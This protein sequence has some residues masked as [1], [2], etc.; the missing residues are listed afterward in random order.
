MTIAKCRS[1]G[2][3]EKYSKELPVAAFCRGLLPIGP[4]FAGPIESFAAYEIQVCGSCGLVDWFVPGRLLPEMKE[5]FSRVPTDA[6]AAT[7]T[8]AKAE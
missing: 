4:L 8:S 6:A 5:K 2:S 1:C 3:T 7:E